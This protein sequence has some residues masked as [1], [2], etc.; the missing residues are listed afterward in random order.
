[1]EL[2]T[3]RYF[4]EVA[5]EENMT[6]AADALHITQPSLSKQIK[7]LEDELGQK[8]F[9]RTQYKVVLTEVGEAFLNR[10]REIVS[11]SDLTLSEYASKDRDISGEL[12]IAFADGAFMGNVISLVNSFMMSYPKIRL[13]FYSGGLE[14]IDSLT[15]RKVADIACN[16]YGS[17]PKNNAFVKT[18]NL[19]RVGLLMKNDDVLA[20]YSELLEE[21]CSSLPVIMPRGVL[22]DENGE[23]IA[24][25]VDDKNI[26][27]FVEEPIS[28]LGLLQSFSAYIFCLEPSAEVLSKNNLA[29]RPVKPKRFSRLYF[30]QKEDSNPTDAMRAFM[31]YAENYYKARV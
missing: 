26:V 12:S 27:A 15:K 1:M 22:L 3:L 9:R 16:Y 30:I 20:E 11:L 13:L 7:L 29:F 25:H 28:F 24:I 21:Q 31:S 17:D 6:R 10:A 18:N 4:L 19:K 23:D 14:Y 2:R 8:L 5:K